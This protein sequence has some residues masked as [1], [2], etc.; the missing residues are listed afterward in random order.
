M[1]KVYDENDIVMNVFYNVRDYII[2]EDGPEIVKT[3]RDKYNGNY[4]YKEFVEVVKKIVGIKN[5][6]TM[7]YAEMKDEF[8]A[9]YFD[10]YKYLKNLGYSPKLLSSM[11]VYEVA[12]KVVKKDMD[13]QIDN[14]GNTGGEYFIISLLEDYVLS[15]L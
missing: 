13:G 8:D 2:A 6:K 5:I 4:T 3:I 9:A 10:E 14:N 1:T 7:M 11:D 12:P 15:Q